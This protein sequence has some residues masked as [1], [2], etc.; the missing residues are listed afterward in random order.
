MSDKEMQVKVVWVC[1][2]IS[3]ACQDNFT[4]NNA[5]REKKRLT[6]E[7]LGKSHLWLERVEVF[8]WHPKQNLKTKPNGEKGLLVSGCPNSAHDY[9]I[10]AGA[11][12]RFWIFE[13]Q[14]PFL[15]VHCGTSIKLFSCCVDLGV[16][17]CMLCVPVVFPT[18]FMHAFSHHQ[19]KVCRIEFASY[20]CTTPSYF[21]VE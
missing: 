15:A 20:T 14:K 13:C 5:Q 18:S 17:E 12:A 1:F 21:M 9:R 2:K 19:C 16:T 7:G 6:E 3:R 8:L 4:R 11:G 10:G